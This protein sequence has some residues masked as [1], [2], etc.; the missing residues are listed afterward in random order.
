MFIIIPF[1]EPNRTKSI[2]AA[3]DSSDDTPLRGL[4]VGKEPEREVPKSRDEK[5]DE[6]SRDRD[7][8]GTKRKAEVLSKESGKIGVTITTSPGSS[9]PT[10]PPAAKTPKVKESSSHS[11]SKRKIAKG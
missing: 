9:G 11:V 4:T 7:Q 10:S 2:D 8:T 6:K 3:S 5:R 1:T